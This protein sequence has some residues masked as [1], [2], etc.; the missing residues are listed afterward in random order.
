MHW[1]SLASRKPNRIVFVGLVVLL[2]SACATPQTEL[3]TLAPEVVQAEQAK[4]RQLALNTLQDQNGRLNDLA[5]ALLHKATSL[6]GEDVKLRLGVRFA[7]VYAFEDEWRRAARVGLGLGDTIEIIGV[8]DGSGADRAGLRVG[9][10]ILSIAS[11]AV[12]PGPQTIEAATTLLDDLLAANPEQL[13]IVFS[14]NGEVQRTIVPL[15]KVCGYPVVVTNSGALNAFADGERIYI[16]SAMMRFASNEELAVILAHEMAHNAMGHIAAKKQ[17]AI[18][19]AIFGAVVDVAM[20]YNG[21]NTGGD[22]AALGGQTGAR[23]F[24]QDF[25]READY[26]GLYILA[27]AG[28]QL[29][30]AP[31]F[32]RHMAVANPASIGLAHSHPTT[33]ERF[34]LMER[35]IA[36]IWH[37]RQTGAPIYP[38][39][40]N[41]SREQ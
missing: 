30:G 20:A 34:V 2:G 33:A 8:A 10:Q 1:I 28:V 6:C 29:D 40:E 5:Y 18:L 37:K 35:T 27:L 16:T 24:S 23:V 11:Y 25:E 7:T 17:N 31:R 14:R 13:P 15:Q 32:W 39:M 3:P 26:V 12:E 19:G 38:E 21:V 22:Y 36:E 4:Q 9:D 41:E